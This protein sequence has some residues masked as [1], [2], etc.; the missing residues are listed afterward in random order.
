[1]TFYSVGSAWQDGDLTGYLDT[2]NFLL[3]HPSPPNVL[4]TSYGFNLESDVSD[5]L[6]KYVVH[7]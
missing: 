1:M 6:N 4:T 3:K 7:S 2:I 5:A